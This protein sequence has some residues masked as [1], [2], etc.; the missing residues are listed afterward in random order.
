MR[1]GCPSLLYPWFYGQRCSILKRGIRRD[2]LCS[3]GPCS[4]SW[5]HP[6]MIS[7]STSHSPALTLL[8]AQL[9]F[10]RIA[11]SQPPRKGQ[12]GLAFPVLCIDGANVTVVMIS[13]GTVETV[14]V[15]LNRVKRG[16]PS[17]SNLSAIPKNSN[18]IAK[19]GVVPALLF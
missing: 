13:D 19:S 2:L 6:L 5:P 18:V 16:S 14:L 8:A 1:Y 15:F 11:T 12:L 3:D 7:R 10:R 9:V 17:F 4:R